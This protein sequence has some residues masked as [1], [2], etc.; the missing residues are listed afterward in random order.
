MTAMEQTEARPRGTRLPRRARR[1]QLLGAAQ[2]VFVAQGYHAAAMDD[3]ADRAGVSKP[4]LYQHFP[5]K[6]ELYLALLDQ[7]CEALVQAVRR[8][9][10]STTDNKLRVAATMDAYFDYVEQEGGAFRLVFESDLTNEP[11]V[12]ERVDRV[13]MDCAELVSA[14]IAEDTDLP[15]EQSKLLAVSLCGLAQITARHWV[16]SGRPVPREVAKSLTASLAW[17]GI[18]GFPMQ[19]QG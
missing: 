5:G 12:R 8:A 16:A 10:A 4:V 19:P 13:S 9:L 18:A 6:L 17:R 2:E 15:A 7:H 14:V 11:A 1:N 3:I